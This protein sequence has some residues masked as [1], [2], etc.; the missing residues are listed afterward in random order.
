M[1][2][3]L[4]ERKEAVALLKELVDFESIQTSWVSILKLS[5]HDYRLQLKSDFCPQIKE[6]A[7][8]RNLLV[9]LDKEKCICTVYK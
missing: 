9:K 1:G 4:L 3:I 8:R 7:E 6:Y 5:D 2:N